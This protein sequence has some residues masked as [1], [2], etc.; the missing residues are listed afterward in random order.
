MCVCVCIRPGVQKSH[1]TKFCV[2]VH[3]VFSIINHCLFF[4]YILKFTK[5]KAPDNS[6]VHRSPQ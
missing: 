2:A 4:S 5:Q 6:E 1:V 3:N